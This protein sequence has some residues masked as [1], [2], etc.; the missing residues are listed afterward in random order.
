M[1]FHSNEGLKQRIS[2]LEVG[3]IFWPGVIMPSSFLPSHYVPSPQPL[4]L[5]ESYN[6][7]GPSLPFPCHRKSRGLGR[8]SYV[9]GKLIGSHFFPFSLLPPAD[10]KMSMGDSWSEG[11]VN[12]QAMKVEKTVE[13]EEAK[14]QKA[15]VPQSSR[16]IRILVVDDHEMVRKGLCA[17]LSEE[18]D[19]ELI[20]E[21]STGND[22]VLLSMQLKPDI[23]LLDI[24]LGATNGLDIAQQLQRACPQMR[25]VI[26]TGL[27]SEENLF[28]ALRIGVH[29][30]L[31]KTLPLSEIL[32]A[33]REVYKGERVVG[34][35]HAVTQVLSEFRR[36]TKEQER[37]RS[38]LSDLEIEL[39]RLAA[40]GCSNKEIAAR[41]FW[42]EVTVKRKMQDIYRKLQVAD[43]AQAVAEAMRMG[44]I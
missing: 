14:L 33:L 6:S 35:P 37:V 19:F 15:H 10:E 30:Y 20:G 41:Q 29:G 31:Q 3:P 2:I 7:Q 24:F 38:G 13:R 42:S 26:M 21:A 44:L 9:T 39:V 22:A 34:E 28:R 40:E 25:I 11:S 36:L 43:R 1:S 12:G 5:I 16:R 17:M 8:R 4:Q 32:K 23:I 27:S 18:E